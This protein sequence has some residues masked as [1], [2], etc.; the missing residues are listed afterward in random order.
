[1][2]GLIKGRVKDQEKDINLRLYKLNVIALF[3]LN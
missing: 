2:T 1:M 3:Y